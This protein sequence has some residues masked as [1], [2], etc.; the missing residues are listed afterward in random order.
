MSAKA[1][2]DIGLNGVLKDMSYTL[3]FVAGVLLGRRLGNLHIID[4]VESY[5][6]GS[7]TLDDDRCASHSEP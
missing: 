4:P 2:I 1:A 5:K 7:R 3:D 6:N